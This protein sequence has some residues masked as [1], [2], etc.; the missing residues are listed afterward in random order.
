MKILFI[1]SRFPWPP[2]RGDKLK[3]YNLIR[4]LSQRHTVALV[5]LIQDVEEEE[6]VEALRPHCSDIHV[7]HLPRWQSYINCLA[8][9]PGRVPFQVAYYRSGLFRACIDEMIAGFQPDV[10]HSHLIRTV[11]YTRE[12]PHP[13]I[14]D[15]TD[16]VSLYLERFVQ[17][18]RNPLK[19][20]LI[21]MELRRMR[22]YEPVI[23]RYE[24]VL[25]CS[26]IDRGVL[27]ERAPGAHVGLL[28]NGVDLETFSPR[29]DIRPEPRRIIFTGNMTYFPNVDAALHLVRDILPLI[30]RRVPDVH[31]FLVG[32]NPPEKVRALQGDG[33]TVTGFVPDIGAEYARSAVAVSP[34]RFGA[35][36]LNKVLEPL[37]L[38]V[39]VVSTSIGILG[40]GLEA[41]T[42]LEVADDPAHFADRVCSLL[43]DPARAAAMGAAASAKVRE[44]FSWDTVA[45]E[46]EAAHAAA[47]D[48][49]ACV[50]AAA[51]AVKGGA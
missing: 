37:A 15:L 31:L 40:L 32:Q 12:L 39:P 38:G 49:R 34:V 35:G 28:Y 48:R 18:E 2:Y 21:G 41:G 50:C 8:A 6:H 16:A 4:Q 19:R 1:T 47:L 9:L 20:A 17:Q 43:V 27:Q 7:V 14:L 22:R 13:R 46:L 33:I 25:V 3:I 23:D 45:R 11:P 42:D 51:A 10:I 29:P 26:D 44:R 36:T 24:G 30:R 5:S